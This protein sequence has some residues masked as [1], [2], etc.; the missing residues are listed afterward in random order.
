MPFAGKKDFTI[1]PDPLHA[2]QFLRILDPDGH[3][4]FQSFEEKGSTARVTPKV[5]VSPTL[6][7]IMAEAD[8]GA[9]IY[10]VVNETDAGG[11]KSENITRVRA[12]WQE[13]DDG[14]S[15]AASHLG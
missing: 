10:V 12:I 8:T 2:Q 13:D 6:K 15:G 11:R 5:M 7:Q 3:F 9:G 14:Y 4:T 1:K